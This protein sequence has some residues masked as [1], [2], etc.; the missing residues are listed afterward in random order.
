MVQANSDCSWY[1]DA[2][3]HS[4]QGYQYLQCGGTLRCE[5]RSKTLLKNCS[6]SEKGKKTVQEPILVP[7]RT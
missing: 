4:S 3:G 6:I 7:L 2:V 5:G 1:E